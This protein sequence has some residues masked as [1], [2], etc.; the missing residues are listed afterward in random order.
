MPKRIRINSFS[1]KRNRLPKP[2][3]SYNT[4]KMLERSRNLRL[5]LPIIG[6]KNGLPTPY[7]YEDEARDDGYV[8]PV[9]PVM[10]LLYMAKKYLKRG[11]LFEH[12]AEWLNANTES[13]SSKT[14]DAH[15][16]FLVMKNR[17]P[18]D[19]VSIPYKERVEIYGHTDFAY[20]PREEELS[21][22][23]GITKQDYEESSEERPV[24]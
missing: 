21:E 19:E 23:E 7:G 17:S 9:N 12:V 8:Y 22:E 2:A 13:Y 18:F 16:L 24:I 6:L 10:T 3:G 1:K 15:G 11:Y 20:T 14:I 4:L 5:G